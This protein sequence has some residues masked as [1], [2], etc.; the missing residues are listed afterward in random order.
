MKWLDIIFPFMRGF[1]PCSD[2]LADIFHLCLNILRNFH[3]LNDKN[4]MI[5]K[6]VEDIIFFEIIFKPINFNK[7]LPSSSN[8][9]SHSAASYY[10]IPGALSL[11]GNCPAL[12]MFARTTPIM[13][14]VAG[15]HSLTY[16]PD[17]V[18]FSHE[19][20]TCYPSRIWVSFSLYVKGNWFR[21]HFL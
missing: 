4:S 14:F 16:M 18:C 6:L 1:L 15:I 11:T 20:S 9:Y 12:C 7:F 8:E 5:E 2:E 3:L 21:W 13:A 19:L 10:F 17:A